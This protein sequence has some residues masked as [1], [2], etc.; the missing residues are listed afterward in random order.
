MVLSA[1]RQALSAGRNELT[2][3]DIDT[4]FRE[5]IPSAQ[6]LEKELQEI[7]A[8]MEC[9]Q[10]SFLP[11]PWRDR[12]SQPSGRAA[13]QERAVALRQLLKE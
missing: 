13:I 2:Q 4:A 9:T 11:P 3:E 12:I 6:A 5:F 7:S 10:L 1:K 8:V